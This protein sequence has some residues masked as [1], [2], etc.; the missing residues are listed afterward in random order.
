MNVWRERIQKLH[1][2]LF[3]QALLMNVLLFFLLL[4][5]FE[6]TPKTDDYDM[7]LILYGASNG[8]Y[9]P[10]LLY[11]NILLGY[12]IQFLLM[13]WPEV[14]WYYILQFAGMIVSFSMLTYVLM[15][16]GVWQKYQM[17]LIVLWLM[18]GYEFYIRITFTKTAGLMTVAGFI[19]VLSL[20]DAASNSRAA[21]ASGICMIILGS[22]VRAS[23][24]Q[25]VS[26]IFVSTFLIFV[27]Q[28]YRDRKKMLLGVLR[29]AV[30]MCVAF[31]GVTGMQ[32]AHNHIVAH[33]SV[34]KD[35]P[36][37]NHAKAALVDY[38]MDEVSSYEGFSVPVSENDVRMWH[39]IL[40]SADPEILTVDFMRELRAFYSQKEKPPFI[41]FFR[42]ATRGLLKYLAT[43]FVFWIFAL[44]S[45]L[46]WIV[47]GEKGRRRLTLNLI[48]C[49]GCYYY[50]FY[51]GRTKHHVDAIIFLA[52]TM[53]S[54][55]YCANKTV[56]QNL[57]NEKAKR[58]YLPIVMILL[59]AVLLQFY[60][61][62][63]SSDYEG[64]RFGTVIS[65][66]EQYAQRYRWLSQLSEDNNH[67]YLMDTREDVYSYP[68][69]SVFQKVEKGFYH[70]IY[71]LWL[72][73]APVM[74]TPLIEFQIPDDNPLK[75]ITDDDR[76]YYCVTHSR[77]DDME[78]VET[79]IQEHYNENAK[80]VLVKKL[81]DMDIYRFVSKP[82]S[83]DTANAM[84]VDLEEGP[85][86]CRIKQTKVTDGKL[87]LE[88]YAY[89]SGEDSYAQNIYIEMEDV[90]SK[91]KQDFFVV[92]KESDFGQDKYDG[93][94]ASFTAAINLSNVDFSRQKMSLLL[95]TEG[96]L[97]QISLPEEIVK[98]ERSE[99]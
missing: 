54:L 55:Y 43:N 51:M 1:I 22:M 46:L 64:N 53:I 33:D 85:V 29:F 87:R 98:E 34:W 62:I 31:L 41:T 15:K 65:Q 4:L 86:C 99:E 36:E 79:Y 77:A 27:I 9:S 76:I 60:A 26:F 63:V 45:I 42:D 37:Y 39:G 13:I 48:F 32:S 70:N 96:K 24:F 23:I 80:K 69:F 8:E 58:S 71:R 95:E 16:R 11:S 92:Q 47:N 93:R 78:I 38:P 68:C 82:L 6:P 67:M 12:V 50:L 90:D 19:L 59:G 14:S 57:K 94:Y 49:L 7:T 35:Y 89:L 83:I 40:N 91:E 72:Y 5:F 30:V 56:E 88:G 66:K 97:Y 28:N 73:G 18:A 52:G 10:F 17:Y 84:K 61:S 3:L 74:R 20:I 44:A 81:G 21:Y 75:A 2:P 25:M